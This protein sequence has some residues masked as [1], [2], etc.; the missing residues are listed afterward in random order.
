MRCP[1]CLEE[2][3]DSA[4]TAEERIGRLE[5]QARRLRLCVWGLVVLG[6]C[7][8]L[9]AASGVTEGMKVRELYIVDQKGRVGIKL[10][11]P[12]GLGSISFWDANREGWVP[13]ISIGCIPAKSGGG[14]QIF[15]KNGKGER[16]VNIV[17]QKKGNV[18]TW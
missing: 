14:T 18:R 15:M 6:A 16:A 9:M 2:G 10:H 5:K 11:A 8:V 1:M 17:A 7:A 12:D 13:Q 4:M 3:K